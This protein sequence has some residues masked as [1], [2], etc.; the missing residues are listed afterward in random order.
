MLL[1]Q[2]LDQ[3]VVL[4][5]AAIDPAEHLDVGNHFW[6]GCRGLRSGRSHMKTP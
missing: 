3:N 6:N 4:V 1:V 5:P 2:V